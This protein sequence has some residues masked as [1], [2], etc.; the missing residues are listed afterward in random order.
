MIQGFYTSKPN[1]MVLLDI[2]EEV[3]NE[4]L[5][6]NIQNVGYTRKSCTIVSSDPVDIVKLAV[7]GFTDITVKSPFAFLT[8]N[9]TLRL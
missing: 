1:A 8:G 5:D 3:K 4:I 6:I 9:P 2:P 7:E